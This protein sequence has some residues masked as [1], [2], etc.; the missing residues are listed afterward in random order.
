MSGFEK[1]IIVGA[2]EAGRGILAEYVR[3]HR[4]HLVAGFVDDDES[5]HGKE[6]E[7]KKVFGGRS[8]LAEKIKENDIGRVII[9]L[10]SANPEIV[11]M[12]VALAMSACSDIAIEILPSFTRFLDGA[13]TSV[14]QDVHLADI[15]D[16][17]EYELDVSAIEK[18]F[19][20]KTVLITGAGG[21]IGSEI[22]RQIA[23]FHPKRIVCVGRGENSIYELTRSLEECRLITEAD[24]IFR[25]CDV[26]DYSLL[27]GIFLEYKPDIV[28]HA[29]AHKHVPLMEFNEAE[30]L[31]NN[32]G[33]SNN[34]FHLSVECAVS[35]VILV[36]TD[37]AVN[38]ANVMG[39][40]KRLCELTALYYHRKYGLKVSIVRFGNVLGSRGS[41][42]P[43]FLDQIKKG[44][45][46]TVT[47][48]DVTRFFMT[49]PEAALL[50]INAGAY[51]KGGEIFVLE[52]G[53]QYR[54]SEI[55]K[56][57]IEKCGYTPEKDI[58]ITYTG[59]RPGEKLYEE[60][61]YAREKMTATPN[62]KIS[63]LKDTG[64]V[65]DTK[66]EWFISDVLKILCTFK[67]ADVRKIIFEMI[68]EYIGN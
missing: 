13:L 50:V 51:A 33:G 34:V 18:S 61:S 53:H 60:L 57:L 21:S 9:A 43:L 59:L 66:I 12:T 55:A 35:Q 39:A 16:R 29:A 2:G 41:V 42:I 64:D 15:I 65:N 49:I 3:L 17:E 46:V 36:S 32:V 26:K 68:P 20:G 54:I 22:C 23:R 27:K 38:P 67:G 48:P 44:G 6:F 30:A 58:A 14:L 1:I 11:H 8:V 62:E 31:Q 19:K 45:P 10:P 63:V 24:F 4:A 7:G 47:H 56:R 5:K 37:K 52:M 40:S 28:F 25:I